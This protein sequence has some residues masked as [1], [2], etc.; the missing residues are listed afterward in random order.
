VT[1]RGFTLIELL[2]VVA[3]ISILAAIAI[4][5]YLE[6]QVRARV[7]H[8]QAELQTLATAL[9]S[10]AIDHNCYPVGNPTLIEARWIQLTTPIA[11]ISAV[12][13]DPF[14]DDVFESRYTGPDTEYRVYDL[15]VRDPV[16]WESGNEHEAF[17]EYLE[18]NNPAERENGLWYA[19]SQGPDQEIG[20][21]QNWPPG[22]FGLPYNP[23][24][25]TISHGDVYR[26]GP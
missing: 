17:F 24:N 19:S 26:I 14:G 9:E 23:S 13:D 4:P 3:I 16:P 11:Y 2:I 15:L 5:N 10:Y 6:A 1:C 25:G 20:A 18:R 8:A 22:N 21:I 7:A 12:P